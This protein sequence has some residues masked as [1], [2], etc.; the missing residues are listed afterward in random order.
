MKTSTSAF[1]GPTAGLMSFAGSAGLVIGTQSI[2]SYVGD[3]Q[4]YEVLVCVVV[5]RRCA[6]RI[7]RVTRRDEDD[8][9]LSSAGQ[10]DTIRVQQ[11]ALPVFLVN[12]RPRISPE[13]LITP[14]V[15]VAPEVGVP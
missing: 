10:Q 1:G 11:I 14:R 4:S 8:H 3:T 5:E 9:S 6:C 2:R 7:R 15:C 12:G 13:R